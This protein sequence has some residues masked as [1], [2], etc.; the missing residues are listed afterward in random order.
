MLFN[1]QEFLFAFLPLTLVG[2]FLLGIRSRSLALYWLTLASVLFYAWWRPVNVLIIAPSIAI[3]YVLARVLIRLVADVR[4]RL[5]A[6]R[7]VLA[8]GIV[9]NVCFLGYFKYVNF[10]ATVAH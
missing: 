4:P 6:A 5:G 10:L 9:F 3:N 7:A 1:S 8:L 2:F